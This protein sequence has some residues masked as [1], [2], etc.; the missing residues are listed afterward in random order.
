MINWI[1]KHFIQKNQ[2]QL[3]FTLEHVGGGI[4]KRTDENRELLELL[5]EKA[6]DLINE[7]PWIVGWI[8]SN[9]AVFQALSDLAPQLGANNPLF[10]KREDFPRKLQTAD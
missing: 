8:H 9:D 5:Q 3:I 2:E 6:P 7:C 1:K 4:H 10:S